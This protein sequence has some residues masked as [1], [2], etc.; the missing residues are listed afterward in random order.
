MMDNH[1][2]MIAGTLKEIGKVYKPGMVPMIK[3]SRPGSWAYITGTE[4]KIN[5]A[6]L[7]GDTRKLTRELKNYLTV[8]KSLAIHHCSSGKPDSFS[9]EKASLP[10]SITDRM[11]D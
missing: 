8:W 6:A 1:L 7:N 5:A 10:L 11:I 2:F 4:R 9:Q 3:E